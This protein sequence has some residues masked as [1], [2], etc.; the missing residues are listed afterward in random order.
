MPLTVSSMRMFPYYIKTQFALDGKDPYKWKCLSE[1]QF[2]I[3]KS[4]L[5]LVGIGVDHA[6]EQE[7]K[8]LKVRGGLRGIAANVNAR[9]RFFATTPILRGLCNTST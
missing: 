6:G 9:N 3:V 8:L 5:S 4:R 7:N 1:G 2:S